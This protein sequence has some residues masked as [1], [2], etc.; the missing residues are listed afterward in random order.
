MV[1]G[2]QEE[3]GV[4]MG[5]PLCCMGLWAPIN[6]TK[7]KGKLLNYTNIPITVYFILIINNFISNFKSDTYKNISFYYQIFFK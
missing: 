3:D 4:V 6:F 5:C 1:K 7:F 2:Q